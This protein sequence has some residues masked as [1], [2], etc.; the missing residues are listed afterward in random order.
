MYPPPLSKAHEYNQ[1]L[2]NINDDRAEC[3]AHDNRS[4]FTNGVGALESPSKQSHFPQS[5]GRNLENYD[6]N[7]GQISDEFEYNATYANFGEH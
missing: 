6:Y 7:L 2:S 1:Y 4:G 5:S 3:S